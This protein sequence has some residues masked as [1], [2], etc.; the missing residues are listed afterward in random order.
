MKLKKITAFLAAV[1]SF[2]FIFSSCGKSE[3]QPIELDGNYKCHADITQEEITYS[4]DFERADGAGWKAVFTAPETIEGMEISLFN[5]SCTLNFKE[6]SYT[7]S[8]EELPQFGIVDLVTSALDECAKRQGMECI[9]DGD[10]VTQTGEVKGL[11]FKAEF[12]ENKLVSLD[13]T[14]QLTVEFS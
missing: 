11:D 13:I 5:D 1:S 3:C 10:T 6:L 14:N 4:A 12:K 7:A 9:K 2:I 8:R